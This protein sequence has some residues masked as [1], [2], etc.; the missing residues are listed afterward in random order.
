MKCNVGDW[1]YI[2]DGLPENYAGRLWVACR[3]KDGS[4]ENWVAGGIIYG[5]YRGTTNP[6]G[7]PLLDDDNYEAY[8]WMYE[9]YPKPPKEESYERKTSRKG[10]GEEDRRTGTL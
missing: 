7:I 5:Y 6:W 10:R 1:H 8:A 4:R 2:K 9:W 3:A